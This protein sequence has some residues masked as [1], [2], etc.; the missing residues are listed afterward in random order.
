MRRSGETCFFAALLSIASL[1]AQTTPQEP[2]PHGEV[3]FQSHGDPPQPEQRTQPVLAATVA[4]DDDTPALTDA[5]RSALTVL[6]Y[7]LDTR[8]TPA[9]AALETRARLSLRNDGT[10]PLS[11][12]ALQISSTLTWNSASSGGIRLA[13]AQHLIDTDADHTGRAREAVLTLPVPLAPGAT[14]RLD[15]F[16]SG[17]I[18]QD[19]TRLTRIGATP[20]QAAPTDWDAIT[21]DRT[22]LRGF[23]NVL[24]YP[25]AAPQLLLGDG[26]RLFQAVAQ[27][28]IRNESTTIHLHL[29]VQYQGEPPVAAYFCGRRRALTA[30]PDDPDAPTASG[31]GIATA[32]FPEEPL[33]P[34]L[35]SLF[36]ISLPEQLIAPL[37]PLATPGGPMLAVETTDDAALPK[38]ADS[39]QTIAPL[40]Q[41][42]FGPRPLST[43]T[44]LDQ[45]DSD[46]QPFEDG[47]FLVAPV[48]ALATSGSA[49]A[50]AHSLTHAWVQTGQPWV[51]EGLAQFMALLWTEHD[52]GRDA[53]LAQYH[54]LLRPLTLAEIAP[55]NPAT[56]SS[57]SALMGT[58]NQLQATGRALKGTVF[59][60]SVPPAA[61]EEGAL[62][63]E[64]QPLIDASDE[65]YYRRKSAAVFWMLRG[66]VGDEAL[67]Q[68]LTAWR[69]QTAS[70]AGARAQALALE[71]LME[72]TSGKDLAWFFNDWVLR[73]RGLPDLSIVSVE[74]RQL[75]AGQGHDSGWL[76]AVTVHND[77][78]PAVEVPLTVHAGS[79]SQQQRLRVPGFATVTERV[80]LAA[81][82]TE[83]ILNDGITPEVTATIHTR[84][85]NLKTE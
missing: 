32:D 81:P 41:L 71:R 69:T 1:A 61:K 73:D 76:V 59:S 20:A 47:P 16:Y 11:V 7:D 74:P 51:D 2:Q 62:A 56:G 82:P 33:G 13:L 14:L 66:I 17:T 42:W 65:I 8:L 63:P 72:R 84:D 67:A 28:R 9:S 18:A 38:L 34:R 15:A 35:P 43:L 77:G 57:A 30:L 54:E 12:L 26:A 3:L 44:V 37:P 55:P 50:L 40:L 10:T 39:A 45:P 52:K 48:A 4:P 6:A 19:A 53:A 83:V 23:G 49:E 80:I 5:Q 22:G 31:S 85:L 75:P 64:G 25:V 24:W 70:A 21:P 60:P 68:A 46:A 36:V 79:L 58:G 78:A 29:G 27:S